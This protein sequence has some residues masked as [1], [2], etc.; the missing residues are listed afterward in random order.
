MNKNICDYDFPN[1][2]KQ[3]PI[4]QMKNLAGDIREFLIDNLSKTGGHLASNL[5]V[6]ELTLALHKTFDS[7][8]DKIIWDVGH[9]AYA[10][11]LLT[12]RRDRFAQARRGRLPAA[13]PA[14]ARPLRT[15]RPWRDAASRRAVPDRRQFLRQ[16][17]AILPPPIVLVK[18]AGHSEALTVK[19]LK[20]FNHAVGA[21]TPLVAGV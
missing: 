7:P 14:P 1:E 13:R 11:K 8:T 5:G 2:L 10:H 20:Q 4:G 9:Q 6:V 12:G 3:M 19:A 21:A 15:P 16:Q 18:A 17:S